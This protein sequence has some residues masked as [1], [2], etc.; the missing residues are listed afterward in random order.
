M[1]NGLDLTN[2]PAECRFENMADALL[3]T[4]M[5]Q[6][7]RENHQEQL[8]TLEPGERVNYLVI[9]HNAELAAALGAELIIRKIF[10]RNCRHD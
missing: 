2:R 4:L 3:R 6:K 9:Q 1:N 10:N 7:L 5:Q 8:K